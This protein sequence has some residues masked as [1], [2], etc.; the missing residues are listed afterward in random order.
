MANVTLNEKFKRGKT[1]AYHKGF[2]EKDLLNPGEVILKSS[3][4]VRTALYESPLTYEDSSGISKKVSQKLKTSITKVKSYIVNF[5]QGIKNLLKV[6]M[7]VDPT[8]V[9]FIIEDELS[10]AN[11]LFDTETIEALKG[12]AN[13]APTAKVS[14]VI[15]KIEVLYHGEKD[16]MSESLRAVANMSDRQIATISKSVNKSV[17]T[18][19]VGNDYRVNGK[20]LIVNTAEI[21][22][23]ITVSDSATVGDK[24]IFSHQLKTTIGEVFQHEI[25]TEDGMEIDA[26]FG[27]R[28]VGARVVESVYQIGTA[29]TLLRE[30]GRQAYRI[31]KGT[32]DE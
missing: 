17:T 6:G 32:K 2:F 14:G 27:A 28:S 31:Y 16:D 23:Y 8:S 5:E 15:D 12:L 11:D 18:G 13:K 20:P 21:K 4:T 30:I 7:S 10:A 29:T 9:L 19:R 22:I 3:T 25:T 1:I 26:I 24:Q